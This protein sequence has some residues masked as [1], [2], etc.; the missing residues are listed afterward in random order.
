MG[1]PRRRRR[2]LEYGPRVSIREPEGSDPHHSTASLAVVLRGRAERA[3]FAQGRETRVA[4]RS[5]RPKARLL[6][7]R[8][9]KVCLTKASALRLQPAQVGLVNLDYR[10]RP[11]TSSDDEA[12]D[13]E[14]GHLRV[15]GDRAYDAIGQVE[16]RN[17]VRS[18]A[19]A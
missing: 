14:E 4:R 3:L 8:A 9:R 10:V 1:E 12:L 18:I 11:G 16:V 6:D 19:G 15:V 7:Q 2:E 13:G 5:R 17:P